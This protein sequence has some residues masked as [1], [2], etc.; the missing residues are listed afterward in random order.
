M[1]KAKS[2]IISSPFER[3]THHWQR[4]SDNKLQLMTGRRPAGYEIFDTRANTVRAVQ[5]DLVNR[6]RERVD[7]WRDAGYPGVTSVT[8][9]LLEHWHDQES[10]RDYA[11]YF[12][13][14]EAIETLIWHVEAPADFKQGIAISGDGGAWE[15]LCNKMATGSGKTTVMAMIITWQVL[16]ALTYPK[17]NKDFSRA[18]FIVAPGLTVKERLQIL[19]P[20]H[21]ENYYDAFSLCPNEAMRQKLN[22]AELLIENWHTL[23]PLKEQDRSVVKKGAESDEAYVRRILG[24]LAGYK[25]LVIINDEA[26]HAYRKPAEIKVSKKDAEELGINLEEATRWIEGLDRIHKMRR[27]IRCFDL[28]ATPFAPTGKTSTESA[29]FEWVV[30]DFGLNDA[31]E[32]GLV[33][34]PRVVVRDNAL[35]NAQ[36]YK[37]KLY[38]L[39][40]EPEVADDLNR[41]GA[42]PHEALPQI[43]QEAYTLL[44][45]DWREALKAWQESGHASPP[46]ML[47][48]CNRTE[49]AARIE[50]YFRQGDA[51]W[52]ELK[53]PERTL[54]VDS[55]VLEKAEIGETA[56]SNKEYEAVLQEILEAAKIPESKKA[57]LRTLKK[58]QLLRAIIDNVGK[59]NTAGQDLQKVISVAMLSEGW[60][61]KNVTH[62]MGLRAFTSQLLCEQVI[63]RGLRRVSYDT[64]KVLCPDGIERD[65]FVPEYVNVFGV[66]LSIFQDTD[67]SDLGGR[68]PPKPSTQIES[69]KERSEL[70]ISW[71]NVLRVDVTV[72]PQLVVDWSKVSPLKLD[73]AE[74]HITADLAPA[75]GGAT[76]L[77]KAVSIDLEKLPEE[78]RLQ[79][80][81]FVAARKAFATMQQGF[82][83]SREILIQ[84][85]IRLV[86]EFFN[87]TQLEIPSLFHQ[88]PLRK[89]I[90]IAVSIDRIVAHVVTHVQQQN[91][92]RL[93]PV[94]D[95]EFP[96]GSTRLMRTWYSTKPCLDTVKSQISHVVADST[97]EAYTANV[98]EKRKEVQSFSKNDHLGFNIY[99][100]WRGSKRKF[101]PDFLIKLANGKQLVLEIKGED[102][103]QNRA[104]RMALDAWVRAVNSRGGFGTWCWDVVKGEPAGV[105]D[106]IVHHSK[107]ATHS[108]P[109][110]EGLLEKLLIA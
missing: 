5:L 42:E 9:K 43:V 75:L 14:L 70:E 98:L 61:A 41:R 6:I 89:R 58:E 108:E 103:E 10:N 101:V 72:Q 79:R 8:R 40:R 19:Q 30:S 86:E 93:E 46:V 33:K 48:V 4:K 67:E 29:L 107:E 28:S 35:P 81:L 27:V 64:E 80:L 96:I 50:H 2:L 49:T 24:K 39:Y 36:T 97:W 56:A 82:T 45:A 1:S 105:D 104:K 95:S 76:D 100:L 62:I 99:Y 52:P 78:F 110:G 83:G 13:Q 54:R 23:M 12:C 69:L 51:Y 20:G 84:Q 26:H 11:F 106:V 15:R 18:I 53:A 71:P 17:R 3:P 77:S 74:I 59:R 21:P 68:P 31:I 25:D 47:T 44:G 73:P 90:L 16:N 22:Q 85:L 91:C 66:P 87:S 102:S 92:E 109:I 38:H 57:E 7:A 65:L 88:D 63:G 55:K 37:S 94:F 32:A 60:D 34:T